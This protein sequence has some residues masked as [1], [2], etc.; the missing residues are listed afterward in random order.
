MKTDRIKKHAQKMDNYW[1][2]SAQEKQ[3]WKQQKET[4]KSKR[5]R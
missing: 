4:E 5:G 3:I 2:L 1:S